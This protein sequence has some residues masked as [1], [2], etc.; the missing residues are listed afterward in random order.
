MCGRFSIWS[1]K[2]KILEHYDLGAAPDVYTGYNIHPQQHI[3]VVRFT[4]CKELTNLYWGYL[5]SW[6]R[7]KKYETSCATSEK[8]LEEKPFYREAFKKRRC[9]I[10]VNGYYEWNEE[11]KLRQPYFIKLKS[12]E[13]FSFAGIWDTWQTPD[14]PR[15][16][17]TL[18]T[19]PPPEQ[20]A[21]I[22]HRATV[23]I[24]PEDYDEWLEQGGEKFI[25]PYEGD[26]DFWPVSTRVNNPRNQGPE[27]IQ[28][29]Y[30]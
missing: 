16:G 8:V 7:D 30:C 22:H 4:D 2:N 17:V 20:I 11:T 15:D 24:N 23:I 13:L 9:L 18:I 14:G 3:P 25:R 1:D 27:L 29:L 10:P 21:H 19:T 12:V 28:P 6:A 5:P 26:Y